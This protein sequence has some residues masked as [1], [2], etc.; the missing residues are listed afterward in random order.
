M[1]IDAL[2]RNSS[3]FI[4][5]V[6]IDDTWAEFLEIHWYFMFFD[7]IGTEFLEHFMTLAEFPEIRWYFMAIDPTYTEFL[8]EIDGVI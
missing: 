2:G 5:I 8:E 3:K 1:F 4:D 7:D 6:S